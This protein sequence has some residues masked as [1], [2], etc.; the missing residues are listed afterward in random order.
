MTTYLVW[1]LGLGA[2]A[3]TA[4]VEPLSYGYA[5]PASSPEEAART[6]IGVTA[7]YLRYAVLGPNGVTVIDLEPVEGRETLSLD[8]GPHR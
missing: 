2:Q 1:P 5:V 8:E 6:L 7:G 3:Y 4:V